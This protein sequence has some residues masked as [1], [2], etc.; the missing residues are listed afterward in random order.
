MQISLDLQA[1]TAVWYI[2]GHGGWHKET[3]I[4][5]K[6]IGEMRGLASQRPVGLIFIG[7]QCLLAM[8]ILG[9]A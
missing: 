4:C 9:A 3:N 7:E 6:P 8:G 2:L 5:Y 1:A